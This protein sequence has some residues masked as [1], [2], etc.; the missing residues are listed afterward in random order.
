M[1]QFSVKFAL[2][3]V[4]STI[5]VKPIVPTIDIRT[6]PVVTMYR[7]ILFCVTSSIYF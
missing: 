5:A 6:S 2:F 4:W 1:T 3:N 7:D